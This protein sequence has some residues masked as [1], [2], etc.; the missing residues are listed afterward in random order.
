MSTPAV[1]SSLEKEDRADDKNNGFASDQPVT[2]HDGDLKGLYKL[3]TWLR[4]YVI[5]IGIYFVGAVFCVAWSYTGALLDNDAS[6]RRVFRTGDRVPVDQLYSGI[7]LSAL[8]TPASI[9]VQFIT[10]DFR[11]LHLF[12]LTTQ[13]P[14]A[15]KDL[16]EIADSITL[17]SLRSVVKYS[18]WY[19][20]MHAALI[21]TRTLIIPVGTLSLTVGPYSYYKDGFGVVGL[22][23][24]AADA[25]GTNVTALS[26]AMGGSPDLDFHPSFSKNDTFL[27]Q[28][29]FTFVGSLVSQNAL[30]NVDSGILGPVP[31]H[32]LTFATN[33]TYDG[34]VFF[35]WTANCEAATEVNYTSYKEDGNRIYNFTLPDQSVESIEL[36]S[37]GSQR[38]RLWS[39][40][41]RHG[42]N[43]IPTSG[44][45]YFLS[46]T[47]AIPDINETALRN[48]GNDKSLV[49]TDG[50]DWISRTKC[51]PTLEWLVGSCTFNGT[52]MTA[53]Y[54]RSGI[55]MSSLDTAA[56]DSLGLY[57]TAIPWYIFNN[58]MGI[59]DDTLD[60]LYTIPTARDLGHFFGNMAHAIAS[61]S[62]AG[63]FGTSEVPTLSSIIK[64]V[65]IVRCSVLIA[66]TVMLFLSVT[67]SIIDIARNRI[68]HLPQLPSDF[69]AIAH[70]VRGPWWDYELVG[71]R[72]WDTTK[73]RSAG[74]STVMFGV[75]T[76]DPR[77]LA[78]L[79]LIG[80]VEV[81]QGPFI[82][83][84]V[85]QALTVLKRS[86]NEVSVKPQASADRYTSDL[87]GDHVLQVLSLVGSERGGDDTSKSDVLENI[88]GVLVP[89]IFDRLVEA[90]PANNLGVVEA[91]HPLGTGH[92]VAIA[93]QAILSDPEL[94]TKQVSALRVREFRRASLKSVDDIDK[95]E[96]LAIRAS[97]ILE[98]KLKARKRM[99][100]RAMLDDHS[101]AKFCRQPII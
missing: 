41:T 40:S 82:G 25:A 91:D 11:R 46:A 28:T 5:I 101:D 42:S 51:T 44:T 77:R 88:F 76:E 65:Y 61:I 73:S 14:V 31:T 53:C 80:L 24:S 36:L 99:H 86:P 58:K 96:I 19:G 62:T 6:K 74:A 72:P 60:A 15:I 90:E 50:G 57:M 13:Q 39:N 22:P 81:H 70:A 33:T 85:R 94:E 17:L 26:S 1:Y 4:S 95:I 63:Y 93:A 71:Y 64:S 100:E 30:A 49:Q 18:W 48:R 16:D 98:G 29:V 12:S 8:L 27:T 32:N 97:S 55:N 38:M 45:T 75:D 67:V 78:R 83:T 20:L 79:F 35:S 37:Q 87:N 59:V 34:L 56:L 10:Y 23:I 2:S 68:K 66:V 92:N 43:K 54:E 84:F 3:D 21:M 89:S 52:I 47:K 69:V 7:A 9:F